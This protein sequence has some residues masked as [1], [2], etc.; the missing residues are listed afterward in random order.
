MMAHLTSF[1]SLF[2]PP[3]CTLPTTALHCYLPLKVLA[4]IN[5]PKEA[6]MDLM[7]LELLDEER[8]ER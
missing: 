5:C 4:A 1:I 8:I 3:S 2:P 7:I 6:S